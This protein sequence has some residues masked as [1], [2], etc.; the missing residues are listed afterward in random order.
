MPPVALNRGMVSMKIALETT[1]K[2]K[3]SAL[4]L[5]KW[6]KLQDQMEKEQG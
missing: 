5:Q 3:T 4:T 1:P 2:H 6:G